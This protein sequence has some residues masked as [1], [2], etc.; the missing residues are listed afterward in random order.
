MVVDRLIGEA[1][2]SAVRL[3][4][5][6]PAY[7]EAGRIASTVAELRAAVAAVHA[8]GGVEIV[9][10]DDGSDDATAAEARAAGADVVCELGR[11]QG[12]G[13]AVRTGVRASAGQTVVFTDAD[14][15][16]S[17]SHL[18]L[19]LAEV[20]SGADMV[21]GS[22][23]LSDSRIITPPT[24]LRSLGSRMLVAA[25]RILR[26]GSHQDTQCGLK[27]FSREAA[28]HL[29]GV[30]VVNRFAFDVELLYLAHRLGL[31]VREVPV[32]VEN[33]A[34]STVRTVRD[35]AWMLR[36]LVR[37]RM[38]SLFG[39]YEVVHHV[40]TARDDRRLSPSA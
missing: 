5:V 18:K 23:A 30:A 39:L 1:V 27:A 40:E 14:L 35:G 22:R 10:V 6:V 32:E 7:R 13:A 37:I 19:L 9:V 16:Y 15:A 25:I 29:F 36:D 21:I 28:G 17:P 38:R 26:L 3:S 34:A 33:R 12:K 31:T 8:D 24:P 2:R 11:N 20:E 4:V